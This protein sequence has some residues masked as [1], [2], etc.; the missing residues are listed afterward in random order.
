MESA[1][2]GCTDRVAYH[3]TGPKYVANKIKAE[4]E[5][6]FW[7]KKK[8][9]ISYIKMFLDIYHVANAY[10]HLLYCKNTWLAAV[11]PFFFKASSISCISSVYCD[12]KIC[13]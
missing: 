8:K 3:L 12:L 4:T 6:N 5:I 7:S 2:Q 13:N 11:F 1:I 9:H 10:G